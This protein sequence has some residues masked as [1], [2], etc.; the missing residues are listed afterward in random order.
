MTRPATRLR[1]LSVLETLRAVADAAGALGAGQPVVLPTDTVYSVAI[2]ARTANTDRIVEAIARR[3]DA[4]LPPGPLAWIPEEHGLGPGTATPLERTAESQ[5]PATALDLK[6]PAHRILLRRLSPGPAIFLARPRSAA[7][8]GALGLPPAALGPASGPDAAARVAFR[9]LP[10]SPAAEVVGQAGVPVVLA[11]VPLS[12]GRWAGTADAAAAII[13]EATGE[14]PVVLDG[15]TLRPG[16]PATVIDLCPD[17]GWLIVRPGAYEERFVAAQLE[18]TILLVCSGNTCRSP[19]AEAIGRHLLMQGRPGPVRIRLVSAGTA[20]LPG[21]PPTPEAVRAIREVGADPSVLRGAKP[22]TR[23]LIDEADAVFVM[24][25]SHE[26]AVL[27]MA[28]GAADRVQLL[29]PTGE[30][31]QDPI[32]L[33]QAIYTET[34]RRLRDALSQRFREING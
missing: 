10:A 13:A 31:I 34:A 15:G 32:G 14:G 19:M 16:R 6:G 2:T 1:E 23:A 9:I 22:L 26:A 4:G 30:E 3:T 21:A 11:E 7:A 25:R 17:G 5:R 20:A 24:T 27:S 18:Q 29:D 33:P 8:G 28:P 12:P